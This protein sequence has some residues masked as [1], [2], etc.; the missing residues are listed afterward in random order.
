LHR[1]RD[2]R[3]RFVVCPGDQVDR[4]IRQR[5]GSAAGIGLDDDGVADER[6]L[7]D[8]RGELG[9]EL[10]IGQVQRALVDEPERRGVPERRRTTVAEDDLV[11]VG[12]REQLAQPVADAADEVL[13]RRLPVRRAE[14]VNGGGQRLQLFRPYLGRPATEASV[15][16]LEV[17]GNC[18]FGHAVKSSDLKNGVKTRFIDARQRSY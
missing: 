5:L 13:D 3:R 16:G 14:Q 7:D 11:T 12:Q 4:R 2:T 1:D 6:V 18:Q 15:V 8:A 10:A 9:T 17:G